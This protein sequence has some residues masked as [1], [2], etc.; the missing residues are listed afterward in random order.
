MQGRAVQN[1]TVWLF[2]GSYQ[3]GRGVSPATKRPL[4]G[5]LWWAQQGSNL[6]PLACKTQFCRRQMS[7]DLA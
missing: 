4:P 6:W 3:E 5:E 1:D 2:F 7:P